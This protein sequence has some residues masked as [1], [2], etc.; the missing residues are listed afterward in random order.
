MPLF[1]SARFRETANES[2]SAPR[3]C[4]SFCNLL[5][6]IGCG[7]GEISFSLAPRLNAVSRIEGDVRPLITLLTTKD[8]REARRLAQ[9]IEQINRERQQ[10]QKEIAKLAHAKVAEL[11]LS[12][13]RVILLTDDSWPLSLLGLVA[14]D[15][16]KTY[17]RPAILLQTNPETGMAAGSARSDGVVDLYAALQSQRHFI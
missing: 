17:G 2:D 13:S 6:E 3:H 11:D 5:L 7:N 15:L 10:R 12:T 8:E 14:N 16:V 9:R 1:G 4:G